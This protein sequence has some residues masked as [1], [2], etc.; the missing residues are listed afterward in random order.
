MK[1]VDD[2]PDTYQEWAII[3]DRLVMAEDRLRIIRSAMGGRHGK[4]GLPWQPWR[5]LRML[6][7][8]RLALATGVDH[9]EGVRHEEPSLAG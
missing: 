5:W 4:G 6:R 8:I 1:S 7:A 3:R 9:K 2:R